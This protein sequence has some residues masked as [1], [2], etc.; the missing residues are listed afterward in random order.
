MEFGKIRKMSENLLGPPYSHFLRETA[1]ML[2]A[3]HKEPVL[4]KRVPFAVTIESLTRIA[5]EAQQ[6][7]SRFEARTVSNLD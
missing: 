3:P 4:S 1:R 2:F 6:L 7:A 5:H